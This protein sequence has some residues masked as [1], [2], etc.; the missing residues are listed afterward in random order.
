M[1]TS[2]IVTILPETEHIHGF[3]EYSPCP[4][5]GKVCPN[6]MYC[7]NCGY[8]HDPIMK[9]YQTPEQLEAEKENLE[10]YRIMA[11][12][13]ARLESSKGKKSKHRALMVKIGREFKR[14]N[15][16]TAETGDIVRRKKQDGSY[17]KGAF[18]YIRTPNGWRSSPSKKRKPTE[19]QI[20][21]VCQ[22]PKKGR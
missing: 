17:D 4:I 20:R 19:S 5:C 8:I 12:K 7:I 15:G 2:E 10:K 13:Q 6:D 9:K 14:Q 22:E 18:W 16:K 3:G 21:R 1:M 11:K